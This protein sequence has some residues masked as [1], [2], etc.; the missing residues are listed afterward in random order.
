MSTEEHSATAIVQ[1]LIQ[2]PTGQLAPDSN[3]TPRLISRSAPSQATARWAARRDAMQEGGWQAS[4][5]GAVR[6]TLDSGES[7]VLRATFESPAEPL[8]SK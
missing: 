5:W 2:Q 3:V 4:L 7:L 6:I 1:V 8:G